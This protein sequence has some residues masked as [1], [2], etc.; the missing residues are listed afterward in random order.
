M[1]KKKTGRNATSKGERK[2]VASKWS[3]LA[4]REYL[5]NPALR[6]NNQM[7]ALKKKKRVVFT[8]PNPNPNETNKRFIRLA[9][10]D[11]GALRSN[12]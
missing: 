3:K 9:V 1:P 11:L 10:N 2:N 8:I 6:L 5:E 4:R 7:K 12:D